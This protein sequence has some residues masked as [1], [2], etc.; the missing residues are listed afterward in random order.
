MATPRE[1]IIID[2]SSEE[3][4]ANKPENQAPL[5]RNAKR[6]REPTLPPVMVESK[7]LIGYSLLDILRASALLPSGASASTSNA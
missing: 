7:Q 2:S 6:S 1:V 5:R 3:D 4:G